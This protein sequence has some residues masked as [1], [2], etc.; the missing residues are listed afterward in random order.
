MEDRIDVFRILEGQDGDSPR[1]ALGWGV[2]F[3]DGDS[4]V[5]WDPDLYDTGMSTPNVCV[6]TSE[7]EITEGVDGS[8]VYGGSIADIMDPNTSTYITDQESTVTHPSHRDITPPG[9]RNKF[10]A[11][12]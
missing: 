5:R 6:Y 8:I 7:E 4:Y 3:P 12:E 9:I 11:D 1:A 10:S 2:K